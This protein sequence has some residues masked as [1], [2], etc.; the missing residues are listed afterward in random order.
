MKEMMGLG[1]G[2]GGGRTPYDALRD[3]YALL[4]QAN[5]TN[6]CDWFRN[7]P[8][9]VSWLSSSAERT[10]KICFEMK[11]RNIQCFCKTLFLCEATEVTTNS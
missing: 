6:D 1:E 11:I 5:D 10:L 7:R 4:T 3:P 2:K 8:K 9:W